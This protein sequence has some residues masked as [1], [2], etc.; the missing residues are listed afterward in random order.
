MGIAQLNVSI[1]GDEKGY[2]T[3]VS[4]EQKTPTIY[5]VHGVN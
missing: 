1:P 2:Y 4:P 3:S 5:G